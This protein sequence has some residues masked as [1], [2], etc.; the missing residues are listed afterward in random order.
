MI[1]VCYFGRQKGFTGGVPL[2][3]WLLVSLGALGAHEFGFAALKYISFPLQVLC[4][5]GKPIFVMFGERLILKKQHAMAKVMSIMIM[6][7]SICMFISLQ[8]QGQVE[9]SKRTEV[10]VLE[11]PDS[12]INP[13][14]ADYYL[15]LNPEFLFGLMLV[16][17]SLICDG[18]YSPYQSKLA[19]DYG[20]TPYHS[21][22]NMNFYQALVSLAI[23]IWDSELQNAMT[24]IS[25]HP[26]ILI[27]LAMFC[28]AKV[29]GNIFVFTL[30]HEFGALAVATTTTMRK[31]LSIVVSV[32]VE[33]HIIRLTQWICI[34]VVL[35]AKPCC[36][37]ICSTMYN[38]K[39]RFSLGSIWS[40]YMPLSVSEKR[41][42][43]LLL[44]V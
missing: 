9:S 30:L 19:Q 16:T 26:R 29:I 24:F 43:N 13:N 27:P 6:C 35:L 31:L 38:M 39:V 34:A 22:L 40:K 25:N 37:S 5:A 44:N 4:K 28:I 42:Q 17:L 20:I 11:T 33:G 1:L 12:I 3:H 15:D 23:C 32:L 18:Y 14:M 7:G 2:I 10:P 36:T 41:Q 21:M 8:A